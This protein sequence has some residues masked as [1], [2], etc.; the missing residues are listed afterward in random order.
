MQDIVK[1][2]LPT[3]AKLRTE[4]AEVPPPSTS[5]EA[6]LQ[7]GTVIKYTGDALAVDSI[8]TIVTAD[9]EVPAPEGE[10]ILEDGTN[11]TVV[12]KGADSVVSEIETAGA[13]VTEPADMSS[14]EGKKVS[15][16]VTKI[17]E[18]F[19]AQ[20]KAVDEEKKA[21]K[22]E[23]EALKLKVGKQGAQIITTTDMLIAFGEV[24]TDAAIEAP[25]DISKMNKKEKLI[26]A[27]NKNK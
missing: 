6:K 13:E 15:E 14:V 16:R 17:V 12:K 19:E 24:E 21:L 23:L 2:F 10:L 18:K 11:I 26:H 22:L 27:L 7:D 1:K 8:V 9:G 3:W 25:V 20:F 5:K 4:F